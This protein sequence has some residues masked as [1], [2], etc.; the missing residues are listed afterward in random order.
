MLGARGRRQAEK[1][2]VDPA[3]V[4]PGQYL[5]ERF[6][7]LTVGPNPRFDLNTW[8]LRV[9]GEVE[10]ELR[11]TWDELQALPQRADA[12]DELVRGVHR[13]GGG[14]GPEATPAAQGERHDAHLRRPAGRPGLDS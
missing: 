2:G 6:P 3:R 13:R 4:P 1:L 14:G 9:F 10:N 5:T 12:P 7:V 11:L 8:D